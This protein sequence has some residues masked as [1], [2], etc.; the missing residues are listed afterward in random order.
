MTSCLSL[1]LTN[2]PEYYDQVVREWAIGNY[3]RVALILIAVVLTL[4]SVVRIARENG[5]GHNIH[6]CFGKAR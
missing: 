5:T 2:R 4:V 6:A 1:P 3:F